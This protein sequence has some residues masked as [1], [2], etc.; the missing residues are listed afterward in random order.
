MQPHFPVVRCGDCS[1]VY[2]DEHF[3]AADLESFYSGDYYQ[4]A[5]VCHPHEI[6]RKLAQDYVRAFNLVDRHLKGGKLLDFGCARGTFLAELDRRGFAPRWSLQGVDINPDEIRMGREAGLD[7]C[8]ADLETAAFEEESFDAVS[9]LS[10]LE[11][12][13][14]PLGNL[15]ELRRI[16]RPGGELLIIVPHGASLII[17]LAIVASKLL[18]GVARGFTD[19][20]FHEEHLYYF[21]R[22]TLG[23]TLQACG[24]RPRRFFFQPSYLETHPTGPLV[25]LGIM[26]L[27][28]SAWMLRRQTML[29]VVATR[30]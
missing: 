1:L 9:S 27:R 24:F 2:A 15:R 13:Q 22:E 20:V 25:A 4:R 8:C 12:L 17:D 3:K 5:Y 23:R 29:G 16:L 30:I 7:L 10:V 26:G 21:T 14:D 11:H 19:N 6:D 18:G 28:F